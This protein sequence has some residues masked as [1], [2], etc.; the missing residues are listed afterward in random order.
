[1][2]GQ[3]Y[4]AYPVSCAAALEVQ[5]IIQEENLLEN[6]RKQGAYLQQLLQEQVGPHPHVGNIR[7]NG[8]FWGLEFVT[9]KTTKEPF[10]RDLGIAMAVHLMGMEHG[11]MLYPGNGT[12]DGLLGDHVLLAPA[13]TITK[14]DVEEIVRLTA[15][16]V[17]ETFD[18]VAL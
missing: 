15:S 2:H 9:D 3:T 10:S 4:Q 18:K 14:E 17:K 6:V 16:A 5:K 7:G 8:L 11:I 1:M 13:Y 12:V